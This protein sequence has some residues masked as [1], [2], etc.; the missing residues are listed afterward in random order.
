MYRELRLLVLMTSVR[1]L[2]LN[3]ALVWRKARA[4]WKYNELVLINHGA[5]ISLNIL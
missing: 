2:Y 5:R 3:N 4:L 1:A